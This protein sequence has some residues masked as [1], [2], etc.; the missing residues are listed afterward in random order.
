M[1]EKRGYKR[2]PVDG[3]LNFKISEEVEFTHRAYLN[4][5]SFGGLGMCSQ[6]ILP[7]GSSID[8]ELVMACLEKPL[9]GKGQIKYAYPPKEFGV[10]TSRIGVEFTGVSGDAIEFILKRI[11]AQ[12][13]NKVKTKTSSQH[14]DFLPF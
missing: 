8:F 13:A 11:Q 3:S 5:L 14:P 7:A 12:A 10:S 4:N 2:Y 6:D 9:Q 1:H